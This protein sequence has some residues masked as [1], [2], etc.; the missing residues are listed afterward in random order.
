VDRT[1]G[2]ITLKATFPNKDY[3]LWPGQFVTVVLTL[4][5]RP[6]ATIVPS[7]AVQ[8]GQQG[9]YM[10]V[11]KADK[12][13]ELRLVKLGQ[14]YKGQLIVEQGVVPG[15]TV[16]TDGHIRLVPGSKVDIKRAESPQADSD[17]A[18]EKRS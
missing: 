5:N 15:E 17:S 1:T 4:N 8:S 6:N 2:T 7:Q 14:Q 3:K 12:T 11:V 10:F 16:V 9:P 13:V 18:Q